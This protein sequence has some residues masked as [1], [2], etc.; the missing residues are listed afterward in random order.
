MTNAATARRTGGF[1]LI[2]LM[3]VVTVIAILAGI[4][5][6]SYQSYLVRGSREACKSEL[7]QLQNLQ[8]KIYLNSNAYA[9]SLTLAYNGRNDGGLGVTSAKT[10]DNKYNLT[11]S[12]TSGTTVQ[13]YTIT[14]TPVTGMSQASDGNI[15]VASDGTRTWGTA[16]W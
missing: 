12:P 4:A 6:P 1:T 5:Y 7:L 16:T 10:S 11:I 15:T 3:I 8:E 14:A 13:S 9:V 2:E